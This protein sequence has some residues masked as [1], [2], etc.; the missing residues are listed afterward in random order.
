[1]GN[2]GIMTLWICNTK[3]RLFFSPSPRQRCGGTAHQ[4]AAV[5]GEGAG[6]KKLNLKRWRL[7][8][9]RGREASSPNGKRRSQTRHASNAAGLGR[10]LS[11]A[12]LQPAG[13]CPGITRGVVLISPHVP[14]HMENTKRV[15]GEQVFGRSS[16]QM[17][18]FLGVR[19]NPN[20]T[21]NN[22]R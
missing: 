14:S 4:R 8:R 15:W 16:I 10:A 18:S 11:S 19:T 5:S 22:L 17:L 20:N 13:R 6:G 3:E 2:D 12:W 1:M 7:K 9:A 21:F